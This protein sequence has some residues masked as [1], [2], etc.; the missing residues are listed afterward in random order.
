MFAHPC[1]YIYDHPTLKIVFSKPVFNSVYIQ[2]PSKMP[3][4]DRKDSPI[5]SNW[6]AKFLPDVVSKNHLRVG[7]TKNGL[8]G[9]ME[10][11]GKMEILE[12][13]SRHFFTFL[14]SKFFRSKKVKWMLINDN[15]HFHN[16]PITFDNF[17]FLVNLFVIIIDHWKIIEN[18]KSRNELEK[19]P[20]HTAACHYSI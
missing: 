6:V 11:L 16:D 3:Q 12:N 9:E 19:S 14:D 17:R 7:W 8:F 2:A 18:W 4:F 5:I 20:N 15:E 10:I 13:W 1:I